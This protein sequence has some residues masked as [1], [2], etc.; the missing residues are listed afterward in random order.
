MIRFQR[1][2]RRN[3]RTFRL[4]VTEKTTGADGKPVEILGSRNPRTN[5]FAFKKERIVYWLSK[6]AQPSESAHNLFISHGIITGAKIP[7]HKKA[8]GGSEA[9]IRPSAEE[10]PATESPQGE[11]E[12]PEAA[13]SNLTAETQ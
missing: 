1:V 8:K 7:V 12:V 11:S 6:G 13:E 5:A 10:A 9:T 2:G 4:V 3:Q